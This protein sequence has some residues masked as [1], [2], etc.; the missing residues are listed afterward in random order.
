M[1]SP[2]RKL[3][4]QIIPFQLR[5]L[6]FKPII[7]LLNVKNYYRRKYL[8]RSKNFTFNGKEHEYFVALYNTTFENERIVELPIAFDYLSRFEKGNVLEIGNVLSHYREVHYDIVDKYEKQKG[9]INTDII[10]YKPQKGYDLIVSVS[11]FEHIGFDEVARYGEDKSTPL[12]QN[13]LIKAIENTKSLLNPN[14]V[15]VFTA[16]LGFN[17]FLD[18]LIREN[19]LGLSNTYFLKRTSPKNYWTQVEYKDIEGIKYNEPYP[20]ANGLMI[21]VYTKG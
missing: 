12:E 11:T 8:D 5:V 19:R 1:K 10:D 9:V 17:K 14:G 7:T 4:R 21:G 2:L 13:A 6:L 3:A 15:F 16:P 18:S 20:C